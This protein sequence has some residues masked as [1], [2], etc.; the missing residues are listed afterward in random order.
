MALWL[1]LMIVV[2]IPILGILSIPLLAI[3]THHQRKMEELAQKR[4]RIMND[5]VRAEFS[6][7]RAEIKSLRDTTM[8]YDL[9]FDTTM[10]YLDQ[11]VGQLEQQTGMNRPMNGRA[12]TETGITQNFHN[13]S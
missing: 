10:Q 4:Q 9:S 6:A 2:G 3:W 7:L 12:Y 5:D 8:Q 11:R 1:L 13:N